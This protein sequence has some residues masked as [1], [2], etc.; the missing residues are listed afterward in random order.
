MIE[1]NFS[2]NS[3]ENLLRQISAFAEKVE[4][5]ET[6]KRGKHERE[7]QQPRPV[8]FTEEEQ[9]KMVGYKNRNL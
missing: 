9:A 5:K 1:I 8:F 3:M 4:V 2:G 7:V 6:P